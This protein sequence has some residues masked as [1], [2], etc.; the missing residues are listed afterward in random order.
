M[1]LRYLLGPVPTDQA[2]RWQADRDAGRCLAF[3]ATGDIDLAIGPGDRWDDVLARLPAGWRPD[4]VAVNLNYT[5]VP[6]GLWAAPVPLV[7]LA[8]DWNLLW[9]HYRYALRR[10]ELVL[11]DVPG[12]EVLAREGLRHARPANLFGCDPGLLDGPWPDGPRDIDVLFVGNLHPA[13]QRERLAWLGRLA[14]LTDRWKVVIA[15]GVFGADYRALLAR[16]RVVFNRSIRGE[17]NLRAFEAAAAGA[18]LFQEAENR[19]APD[20]FR[21]LRECVGYRDDDLEARLE[22]YLTREDERRAIAAAA[23]GRVAEYRFEALWGRALRVVAAEWEEVRERAGRRP[24]PGVEEDLLGRTWQALSASEGTDVG[25]VADLGRALGER[26]QSA[27]LHNA[28]G[29]TLAL[30][31]A[32][33]AALVDPFMRAVAADPMHLAAALNLAEALAGVRDRELAAHTGRKV[34]A[35]LDR[36]EALPPGVLDAPP[37]PP[38]FDALRVEW[39]RAPPGRTPVAPRRRAR[40]NTPCCAGG[41]T[42]CWR[43]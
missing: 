29:V 17:C 11:I 21:P 10:C 1:S 6:H 23:R 20:Y 33:P 42:R 36:G 24:R 40:P 8:T 5:S 37:Y 41:R 22:H 15:G 38:G 3:N 32:Q 16:A 35:A 25:L 34:L 31:R 18:L 43:S 30:T 4:F 27:A 2:R 9:H 28:L 13:V 7:G 19:E 12:A 14:R 26:P 39:E